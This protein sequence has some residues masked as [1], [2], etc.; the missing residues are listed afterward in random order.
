MA[1]S[2]LA[3][4]KISSPDPLTVFQ[5]ELGEHFLKHRWGDDLQKKLWFTSLQWNWVRLS[6]QG[7]PLAWLVFPT[8]LQQ[9]QPPPE[10]TNTTLIL[11]SIHGD[12]ITPT[13]FC[14]DL[15]EELT[16]EKF[17]LSSGTSQTKMV[18][19][20]PVVSPDSFFKKTPTR[21]N[22]SGVDINRNF[23]TKDWKQKAQQ[24]WGH[25]YGKDPRRN[26]G[27]KAA[28]EPEVIFQMNLIKRYKPD[29]ILSVHAPLTMLDYDGPENTK[30]TSDK[31]A[32]D[33]LV[34]MGKSA[35]GYKIRQ[36]RTYPGSLGQ[37]AG[38]ERKIPT[39]TL[40]LPSSDAQRTQEFWQQ[41]R[42]AV[43]EVVEKQLE[44]P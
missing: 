37:W 30:Q 42:P 36:F 19:V 35:G 21:T 33:L 44:T 8:S 17:L 39:Y 38:I 2:V 27:A 40:E 7:R 4:N 11:C 15:I 1:R 9:T 25:Y 16:Q 22:A 34:T 18:I 31:N 14:F 24:L 43:V 20:A 3:E 32:Y 23:P 29:K 6:Q 41:L 26:P 5:Q 12:E 28:S 10:K 13:K